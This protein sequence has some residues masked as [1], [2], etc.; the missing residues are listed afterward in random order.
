MWRHFVYIHY[1]ADDR[2]PFYVGKGSAR[3]RDKK[4]EY[5]RAY[6]E[7]PSN[8]WWTRTVS[9]H[10]LLIEI[11]AS[12]KTDQE[13]Q[14]LEIE[15]ISRFGRRDLGL[16]PLINRTNGGDG[17]SGIIAS[18]ELRKKRSINSSGPR[19]EAWCAAIRA[20]RKNGGNGG[21][22]KFGDK[23]PESWRK[24]LS[25]SKKG[26]KNPW[27]QKPTPV[28]RK[29]RNTKTGIVYETIKAAAEAEGIN[30]RRLYNH[31]D[32]YGFFENCAHLE[33]L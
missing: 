14:R 29:V 4:Q 1:K 32:G 17:H 23:L 10:G 2:T 25:E 24:S 27:F 8:T 31:F 9:K 6:E 28:A 33:K 5:L 20:S 26:A 19:S 21:V 30:R 3:K 12:C 13:A 11:F 22:V 18:E 15:L 7:R 16:G